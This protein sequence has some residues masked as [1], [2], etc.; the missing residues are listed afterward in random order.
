MPHH[1]G[2][3]GRA[4]AAYGGER[5]QWLDLST[6]INPEPWPQTGLP[7]D[8]WQH[9]PSLDAHALRI[10][11]A[12]FYGA[13]PEQLAATAGAQ[14]AIQA[15]PHC[16]PGDSTAIV[17]PTYPE[18][19]ASWKRAGKEPDILELRK[20]EDFAPPSRALLEAANAYDT[21]IL[22]QPNN[23]T[24]TRWPQGVLAEA[25]DRLG[26]R[27]GHLVVDAAFADADSE[28]EPPSPRDHPGL[29]VLRSLG[30][31]FGLPGLRLGFLHA[32]EGLAGRVR[33]ALGPWPVSTA[34]ETLGERI[35]ADSGWP[36]LNRQRLTAA[37]DRLRALLRETGWQIR[38]SSPLFTLAEA[39]N[40]ASCAHRLTEHRI[41]VRTFDDP[42]L[43]GCI[44]FGLPHPDRWGQLENALLSIHG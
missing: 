19:E 38:G 1:G 22:G 31:F 34:A 33:E 41:W 35:L 25:A 11:A 40:A 18:Y 5:G 36:L 2:D 24:G 9:L 21:I 6:G 16:L 15:L 30:K 23:P 39:R 8:I 3:L 17:A 13:R 4:L 42:A 12:R 20:E 29:V 43:G 37:R 44:R 26:A 32:D 28:A 27:G 7:D 10:V 14:T